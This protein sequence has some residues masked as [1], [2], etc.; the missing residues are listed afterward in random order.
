MDESWMLKISYKEH[1]LPREVFITTPIGAR[2]DEYAALFNIL[3]DCEKRKGVAIDLAVTGAE[4][5]HP[6]VTALGITDVT[7]EF[8]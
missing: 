8:V 6:Q 7:W 3:R 5:L 2:A 1:G 4:Q